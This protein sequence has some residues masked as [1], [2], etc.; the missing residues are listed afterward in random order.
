MDNRV[1]IDVEVINLESIQWLITTWS[2]LAREPGGESGYA[3]YSTA[4][5]VDEVRILYRVAF[6]SITESEASSP[7]CV[8]HA[9]ALQFPIVFL[10]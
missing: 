5:A 3:H 4:F 8:F 10:I 9:P 7:L 2:R 6:H 1:R